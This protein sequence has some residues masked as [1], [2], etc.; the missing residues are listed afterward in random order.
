M[1]PTADL[2]RVSW[3]HGERWSPQQTLAFGAHCL[4]WMRGAAALHPGQHLRF[5]FDAATSLVTALLLQSGDLPG[6]L[7]A[8]LPP[9]PPSS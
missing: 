4:D 9:P 3:R 1:I 5:S 7:A 6:R 2:P 8:V